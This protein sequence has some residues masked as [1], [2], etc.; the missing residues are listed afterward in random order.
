MPQ[1][2]TERQLV[3]PDR[4]IVEPKTVK[5]VK[6]G[7]LVDAQRGWQVVDLSMQRVVWTTRTKREATD[8]QTK[9]AEGD[10]STM[11]WTG[12]WYEE[13]EDADN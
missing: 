2:A 8:V 7:R 13:D 9:L 5:R 1:N 10:E 12:V 4:F 11:R 6:D 3:W